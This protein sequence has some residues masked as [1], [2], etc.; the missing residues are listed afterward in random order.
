[1]SRIN[2]TA[3]GIHL[4]DK[5]AH[6]HPVID[7]ETVTGVVYEYG[8]IEVRLNEGD[9]VLTFLPGDTVV[10]D[11]VEEPIAEPEFD[12]D[13]EGA[14]WEAEKNVMR[15]AWVSQGPESRTKF[16]Q[17]FAAH[18]ENFFA[19]AAKT[20]IP[21]NKYFDYFGFNKTNNVPKKSFWKRL[22]G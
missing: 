12:F 7:G 14:L 19:W 8:Q 15:T 4:G 10:V 16:F 6:G 13:V 20:G 9:H 11:R 3:N 17:G 1:M 18:G 5:W 21:T 2:I 22:L